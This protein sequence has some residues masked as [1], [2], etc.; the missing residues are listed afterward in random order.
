MSRLVAWSIVGV[1]VVGALVVTCVV[2][3]PIWIVEHDLDAGTTLSTADRLKAIND[4]RATLLQG[5]AAVVALGGIGIGA[6]LTWRQIDLHREG[7]FIDRFTQ[8]VAQLSSDH[9][10]TRMGGAYAMEQIAE[11]APDYRGHIAALLA[12]FVRQHAPWPPSGP[13]GEADL[14]RQRYHGGLRD[15][16]G[17]AVAAL[18]RRA[19]I[20]PGDSIALEMADLRGV[21]LTGKDLSSFWFA[22]SNLDDAI[23]AKCD[24]TDASFAGA[25]LKNADLS[26]ATLAGTNFSGADLEGAVGVPAGFGGDL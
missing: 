24:L 6:V 3:V 2:L 22:N 21:D 9:P 19:M 25:S 23:L 5:L 11:V 14:A 4:V 17:A 7:L 10:G 20:L 12:S 18:S 13:P 16:V 15:D 26:G 1:A 8:A